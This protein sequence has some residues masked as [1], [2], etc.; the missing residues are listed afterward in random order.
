MKLTDITQPISTP[1]VETTV[2]PNNATLDDII[3]MMDAAK[4]GLSLA[5]RI[6][7]PI[8]RKRHVRAVFINLNKI[9]G[10][11]SKFLEPDVSDQTNIQ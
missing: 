11:L 3:I 10:A 2:I 8:Q 5:N 7:D 1:I 6:A 4:R 9:R